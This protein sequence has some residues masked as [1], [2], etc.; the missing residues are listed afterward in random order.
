MLRGAPTV[1]HPAAPNIKRIDSPEQ[2]ERAWLGVFERIPK[3]S[4]RTSPPF[5]K[6][7]P[8]DLRVETLSDDVVLV[9]FHLIDD[10]N[11]GR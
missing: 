7:D 11:T 2:F 3:G 9:T 4:G 10:G 1:F 5:M 8:R 6:L